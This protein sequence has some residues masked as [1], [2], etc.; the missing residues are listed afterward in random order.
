MIV[1][2]IIILLFEGVTGV[3]YMTNEEIKKYYFGAYMFRE[4]DDGYLQAFQYNE[5]QM[6]YFERVSD[7]WYERCFA[8]TAKTL[9]FIT[10]ATEAK[11]DYKILWKGSDDSFEAAVDNLITEI[12]YV[13]DLNEEGKMTFTFPEGKKRVTIYLPADAT[14]VIKN[15]EINGIAEPPKKTAK[16]LW[17]GDSITQGFGPL[18]SSQ[19][20]VSVANRI[21]DYDIINEGIG[22]YVYDKN[23]LMKLEGYEP[24]KLIVALG[25]NQFGDKDMTV[26]EE[27]YE[28]LFGIYGKDIPTLCI[29]PLWRGDVP[30]GVPTLIEYCSKIRKIVE[31]YPNIKIVDGFK[32]VPHLPEYYLDNLHPNQL[33]AEVYGRNLVEEIRK[34]GF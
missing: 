31:K 13:K 19:T 27:Y 12:F 21:L 1:Y 4:T 32:L 5:E 20:Y 34:L 11:F 30:D 18:R 6:K 15:L 22:G 33:G 23:S 7:F 8:S 9:E 2:V 26:V 24:D 25:T 10:D 16:V 29:L 17:L 28:T 14:V 3:L